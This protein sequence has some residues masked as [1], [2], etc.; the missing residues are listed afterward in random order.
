MRAALVIALKDL[1]QRLRDRTFLI[2]AVIAPFGLAAIFSTLIGGVSQPL[3]LSY[4]YVDLDDSELSLAIREGALARIE[5]AGI[6][7]IAETSS[8]ASARTAVDAGDADAALIVPDGFGAA[9]TAGLGTE[10]E[11]I[12]ST[13]AGFSTDILRSIAESFTAQLEAVRLAVALV[14]GSGET[15]PEVLAELAREAAATD[16]P[17]TLTDLE[18]D[19]REMSTTTYFAASMAIFFLFFTAQFGVLSLLTERRQGTLPRLVAAPIRPWAIV[20]GKAIGSFVLG[21]VAMAVLVLASSVLLG[22]RWGDPIGVSVLVLS[23]VVAAMG[24]TAL[25]T[26]LARTEE[27][28][29]GWNSIVAVTLAI[30]GGAFFDLSQGPEI[31]SQVSLITPHAWFLEGLDLLAG[32]GASVVDVVVPVAALLGIGL[33]GGAIGLVRAGALV[34]RR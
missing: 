27:Q 2:V 6:A 34:V 14:A 9:V 31:L 8:V 12:G 11:I 23:A 3:E 26:T 25:I 28:A 18:A 33:V 5:D 7:S 20:A 30:L 29:G 24:I 16:P 17:I 21:I 4:A 32:T 10:L 22:A 15:S 1:R 19:T 13:D